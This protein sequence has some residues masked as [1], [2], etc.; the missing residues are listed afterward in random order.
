MLFFEFV[1]EEFAGLEG[2]HFLGGLGESAFEGFV[3][4][5]LHFFGFGSVFFHVVIRETLVEGFSD[6][7][8][9]VEFVDLVFGF[10][11][12]GVGDHCVNEMLDEI[13]LA[14]EVETF[15]R[16]EVESKIILVPQ[17]INQRRT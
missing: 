7:G 12:F 14:H 10:L 11:E 6:V 5:E 9:K 1:F 4:F 16:I 15:H 3:L 13:A 2:G 8:V 17:L